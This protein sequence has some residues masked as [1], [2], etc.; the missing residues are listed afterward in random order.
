MTMTKNKK[1]ILVVEDEVSLLQALNL[2]LEKAGFEVLSAKNGQEGLTTALKEQPDLILLDI[3][4]PVMDGMT[5]L[6]KLRED[7]QAGDVPIII[8]TNL[9]DSEKV[10]E[11]LAN[12]SFDYLVKS[13]WSLEDVVK[14]IRE[15]LGL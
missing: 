3:V 4:M 14:R 1:K 12:Q 2:K 10:S 15:K 6:K 9:T 13:D 7:P 11:A 8:L 5:M